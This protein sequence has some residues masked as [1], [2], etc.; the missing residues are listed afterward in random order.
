MPL[1]NYQLSVVSTQPEQTFTV[2][3]WVVMRHLEAM[4]EAAVRHTVV[5]PAVVIDFLMD[6]AV[7]TEVHSVVTTMT[8]LHAAV[9]ELMTN[10]RVMMVLHLVEEVGQTV[11]EVLVLVVTA[12][13][14]AVVHRVMKVRRMMKTDG[15][16]IPVARTARVLIDLTT[17][18]PGH[19]KLSVEVDICL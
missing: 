2:M 6:V 17:V 15:T 1:V 11:V 8:V 5:V 19:V 10:R 13:Q 4:G 7:L 3:T 9:D 14:M 18:Q 16:A 12:I